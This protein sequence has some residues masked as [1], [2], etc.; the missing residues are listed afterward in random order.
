MKRLFSGILFFLMGASM[1]QA[2]GAGYDV[3]SD[4]F[5]IH[6]RL[7]VGGY[8]DFKQSYAHLV[9]DDPEEVFYNLTTTFKAFT[10]FQ[11][12]HIS[13]NVF[14]SSSTVVLGPGADGDYITII[15]FGIE[16]QGGAGLTLGLFRNDTTLLA[17][18]EALFLE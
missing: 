4:E 17:S 9:Y 16:S 1:V 14:S 18:R 13:D 7:N 8:A 11:T 6:N 2:G 10:S 5:I 3:N 15:S 12:P